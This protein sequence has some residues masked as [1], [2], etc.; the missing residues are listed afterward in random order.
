GRCSEDAVS[1]HIQLLIPGETVCFTC[2]PP[3]VATSGVD[4]RTLKR[5]GVCAASLPT[6][7][8]SLSSFVVSFIFFFFSRTHACMSA[9][10]YRRKCIYLPICMHGFTI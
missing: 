6:T 2:A 3:L 9:Q 8:V 10:T 4:E 1:G 7:M 5:E